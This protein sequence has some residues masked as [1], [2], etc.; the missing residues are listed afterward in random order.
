MS[1]LFTFPR[2]VF[3]GLAILICGGC[4][5]VSSDAEDDDPMPPD[6]ISDLAVCA[7]TD[8]SVTLTWT[9][10]G[11]DGDIGTAAYYDMRYLE[12][13]YIWQQWENA[14]QVTDEPSPSPS[15]ATDQHT[16]SGL[17]SESTY[18]FAISTYDEENNSQGV[19]NSATATCFV[20]MPVT[21]ADPNLEA[22]L[23]AGLGLPAGDLMKSD[24]RQVRDLWAEQMDITNLDGL[25]ECLNLDHANLWDNG[26]SDLQPVAGLVHLIELT[27]NMNSISDI[28]AVAGLVD[29][30]AFRCGDNL[31]TDISAVAGLDSL[32]VLWIEGNTGLTDLWPLAGL[33]G[34]TEL[35]MSRTGV[36]DF[37]PL[38]GMTAMRIF[39]AS[40]TIPATT[41]PLAS[42]TELEELIMSVCGITDISFLV[43]MA[44]LNTV[45]LN[46]NQIV[47]LQPLVDNPGIGAGDEIWVG[48]NPLSETSLNVHIPDRKSVV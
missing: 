11:D 21:I 23:R 6:V 24:L 1:C 44:N 26:I 17:A 25:Q 2:L 36:H 9:A 41:A 32:K 8:T 10:T 27:V 13:P 37:L 3:I 14:V 20:D 33:T 43:G 45:G 18:W 48:G 38:A 12:S 34:L 31:V 39:M 5:A 7:F 16:V 46:S 4:G 29:L 35:R 40:F 42:M 22:V 30:Y 28:S 19:S 47:D 15:G